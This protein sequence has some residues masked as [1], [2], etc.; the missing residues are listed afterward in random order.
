[1]ITNEIILYSKQDFVISNFIAYLSKMVEFLAANS[2]AG[3][4]ILPV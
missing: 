3:I 2:F 4:N 1:M